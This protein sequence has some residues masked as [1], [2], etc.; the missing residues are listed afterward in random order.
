[1]APTG[2]RAA[3]VTKAEC[4][5]TVTNNRCG[6]ANRGGLFVSDNGRLW[7]VSSLGFRY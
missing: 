7:H 1:M 2:L 5:E 4:S 3:V 6:A